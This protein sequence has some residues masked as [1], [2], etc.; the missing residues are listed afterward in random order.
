MISCSFEPLGDASV[1]PQNVVPSQ[2][3][4]LEQVIG[5]YLFIR[6]L[7]LIDENSLGRVMEGQS[8]LDCGSDCSL[9]SETLTMLAKLERN[10][11]SQK[12]DI[13][14]VEYLCLTVVAQ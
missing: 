7:S 9:H 3:C 2:L 1:D 12:L 4:Y 14:P 10:L 5:I 13:F 6:Q 8:F 11:V